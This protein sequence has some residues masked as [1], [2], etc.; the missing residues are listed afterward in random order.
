MSGLLAHDCT[1]LRIADLKMSGFG[2]AKTVSSGGP[3][4]VT[5]HASQ[6]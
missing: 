1:M 4:L 6:I 5:L 3:M 2:D